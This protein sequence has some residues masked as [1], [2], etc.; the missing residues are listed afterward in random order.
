MESLAE[1]EQAV[2]V[3]AGVPRSF[4]MYSAFR[5]GAALNEERLDFYTLGAM[6]I[7]TNAP[8]VLCLIDKDRITFGN[9]PFYRVVSFAPLRSFK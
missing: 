4:V 2:A 8:V 9:M 6:R 7:P 1:F 3:P 5:Q